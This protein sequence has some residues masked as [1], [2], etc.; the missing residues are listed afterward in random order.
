MHHGV[1]YRHARILGCHRITCPKR[2]SV[3]VVHGLHGVAGHGDVL[4]VIRCPASLLPHLVEVAAGAHE[5]A[6]HGCNDGHKQQ[7][8][9]CNAN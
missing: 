1:V 4:G 2:F 5:A 3:D 7:N 6:N 8:G 9:G